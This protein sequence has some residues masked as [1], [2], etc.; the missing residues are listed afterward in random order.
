[1]VWALEG[2]GCFD[3]HIGG[4]MKQLVGKPDAKFRCKGLN[5]LT[6]SKPSNFKG[7]FSLQR[8]H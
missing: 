4:I 5:Q 2:L 6:R 7:C 8:N 3:S 1:M